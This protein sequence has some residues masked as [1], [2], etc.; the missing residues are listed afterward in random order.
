M[1]AQDA[2]SRQSLPLSALS[3]PLSAPAVSLLQLLGLCCCPYAIMAAALAQELSKLSVS[4][5]PS[6]ESLTAAASKGP[7]AEIHLISHLPAV[8]KATADKVWG[9][10]GKWRG[11]A[12]AALMP[13]PALLHPSATPH[14]AG[15]AAEGRRRPAACAPPWPSCACASNWWPSG[16]SVLSCTAPPATREGLPEAA[17]GRQG[18]WGSASRRLLMPAGATTRP[19]VRRAVTHLPSP[20]GPLACRMPPCAPLPTLPASPSCL[21]STGT[22]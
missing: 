17:G 6:L 5:V 20:C 7:A 18:P 22:R 8:L 9:R 21:L 16:S 13:A 11:R 15:Q 10:E 1:S 4:G 3:S 2:R 19:A 14:G 12:R